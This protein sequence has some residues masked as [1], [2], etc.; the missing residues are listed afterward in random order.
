M[1][2]WDKTGAD[3]TVTVGFVDHDN[4]GNGRGSTKLSGQNY[5]S[6][7]LSLIEVIANKYDVS[8][9]IYK[10]ESVLRRVANRWTTRS[11]KGEKFCTGGARSSEVCGWKVTETKKRVKYGDGTVAQNMTVAQ[12]NSGSCVISADSGGPVYTVKSN[13]SVYA[14]GTIS[15]GGCA[16][17][18]DDGECSDAWDGKCTVVFADI[19][20][21]EKALP[22]GV[23]KW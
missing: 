6:G 2:S 16:T 12:K 7:D 3:N 11:K 21:A 4:W 15:A 5:Y 19:A 18:T 1:N 17:R 8:A 14:K 9:R 10:K 23:K 20:L 22:G 13:G